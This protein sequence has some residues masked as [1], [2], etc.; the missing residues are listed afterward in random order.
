LSVGAEFHV[1][2]DRNTLGISFLPALGYQYVDDFT[3]TI[4]LIRLELGV[5][6]SAG[7]RTTHGYI[8]PM[9][10]VALGDKSSVLQEETYDYYTYTSTRKQAAP[11]PKINDAVG[12]IELGVR[13][14]G[15]N[16]CHGDFYIRI[17]NTPANFGQV[18]GN[19]VVA[20]FGMRLGF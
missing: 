10:L 7:N 9:L 12:G 14:M 13:Y 20:Y 8:M 15:W 5:R 4:H 3:T 2:N 17:E 6:L 16:D 1:A 18:K 19:D 11:D